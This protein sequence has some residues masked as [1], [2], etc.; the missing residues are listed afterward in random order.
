MVKMPVSWLRAFEHEPKLMNSGLLVR[1]EE[2]MDER[3]TELSEKYN[4]SKSK[5]VRTIL[6]A[7]LDGRHEISDVSQTNGDQGN[8]FVDFEEVSCP[9]CGDAQGQDMLRVRVIDPNLGGCADIVQID[10]HCCCGK[11]FSYVVHNHKGTLMTG[12]PND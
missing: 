10:Y 6:N 12:I 7:F 9:H 3:V 1:L 2:E 5:V 8:C 4:M 11:E